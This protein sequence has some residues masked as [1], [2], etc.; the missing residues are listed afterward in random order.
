VSRGDKPLDKYVHWLTRDPILR[1]RWRETETLIIDESEYGKLDASHSL[2]SVSM[3][4]GEFFDLLSKIG[5]ALRNSSAP[6]G[7][8][9]VRHACRWPRISLNASW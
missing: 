9:Q 7:G 8:M 4:N 3:L 5:R 1:K 2:R 6:F